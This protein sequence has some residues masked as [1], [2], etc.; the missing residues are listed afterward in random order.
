[1]EKSKTN[2]KKKGLAIASLVCGL[3]G[4]YLST[5]S[6]FAVVFGHL[7]LIKIKKK[8]DKYRGKGM[9]IAGLLL[10]YFGLALALVTGVLH[11]VIRSKLGGFGY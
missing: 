9:D 6:I 1:M 5:I 3:I 8:K 10:G 11:G 7:A 2:S 4:G